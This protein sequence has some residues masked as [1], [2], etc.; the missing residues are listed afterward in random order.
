MDTNLEIALIYANSMKVF[1]DGEPT[2]NYGDWKAWRAACIVENKT[3][4]PAEFKALP[5]ET[6]R[7]YLTKIRKT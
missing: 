3:I 1:L 4:P 2:F 5:K 7:A 6:R